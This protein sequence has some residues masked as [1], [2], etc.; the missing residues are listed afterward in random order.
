MND[1]DFFDEINN[2]IEHDDDTSSLKNNTTSDSSNKKNRDTRKLKSLSFMEKS[3][4]SIIEKLDSTNIFETKQTTIC[5][6]DICGFSKWCA[7]RSPSQ[8]VQ[9]MFS[10]NNFLNKTI[11][12]SDYLTKIE[13]VGD[14]CM[15][16]GGLL[17]DSTESKSNA[18]TS[19]F[20]FAVR[21]LQ[22]INE[23]KTIFK[24]NDIGIRIGIHLS[25]VYGIVFNN[26]K[27]FQLYGSDIN[28]C[29]R[30]ES[31]AI[32]NT[33]H[34]SLKTVLF[35]SENILKMFEHAVVFRDSEDHEYKGVG[36]LS[37]HV[38]HIKRNEVLFFDETV[39]HLE[40]LKQTLPYF[41]ITFVS[42][43]DKFM[44]KLKSFYWIDVIIYCANN[45][46]L[47]D[48][49]NRIKD[50]RKWENTRKYQNITIILENIDI[51]ENVKKMC[52][53]V[54]KMDDLQKKSMFPIVTS[55]K[56]YNKRRS[57]FY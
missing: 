38:V 46:T 55:R 12:E 3:Y 15:I 34:I 2:N 27:R 36:S 17:Q 52:N 21:I 48:I 40:D 42:K 54:N 22:R 26:P 16:V 33:I 14:C 5:M 43:L 18:I 11:E 8:I 23:I 44:E 31:S 10:Y 24:D 9:T 47:N 20:Q 53:V 13:L 50:F 39:C 35:C 45:T 41:T 49:C 57:T 29:S 37:S 7:N 28:V 56:K 1:L 25:D 6:I 4:D 32:K 19:T 51:D 30:L